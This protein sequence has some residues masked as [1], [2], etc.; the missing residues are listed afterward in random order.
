ML[1]EVRTS[2]EGRVSWGNALC[3]LYLLSNVTDT[4]E[5]TLCF[6]CILGKVVLIQVTD[7]IKGNENGLQACEPQLIFIID[8][9]LF[10]SHTNDCII[11]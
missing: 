5:Q 3:F 4:D 8:L 9:L 1:L 11:I 2:A 7:T 6:C 10:I